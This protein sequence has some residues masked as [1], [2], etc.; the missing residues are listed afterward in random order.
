[1][2]KK[3]ASLKVAANTPITASCSATANLIKGNLLALRGIEIIFCV[4]NNKY[5]FHT[6]G[7]LT[8]DCIIYENGLTLP[9]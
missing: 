2:P 5:Y 8:L 9:Y 4:E 7:I 3:E 1:M 6:R